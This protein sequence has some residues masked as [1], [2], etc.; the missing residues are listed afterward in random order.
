LGLGA[1]VIKRKEAKERNL[2]GSFSAKLPMNLELVNRLGLPR[3]I[4]IFSLSAGYN[5]ENNDGEEG[6][7]DGYH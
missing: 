6:R 4:D 1:W 7:R 5:P 2:N 3:D